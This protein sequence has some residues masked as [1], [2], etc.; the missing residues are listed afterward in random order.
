MQVELLGSPQESVAL[1][2]LLFVTLEL[3]NVAISIAFFPRV[4][5]GL[6]LRLFGLL[7]DPLQLRRRNLTIV[8]AI[9]SL[10][11]EHNLDFLL[12]LREPVPLLDHDVAIQIG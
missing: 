6:A 1:S 10:A 11:F 8:A 5:V 2:L 9:Q 7:H 12:E 4:V 3:D